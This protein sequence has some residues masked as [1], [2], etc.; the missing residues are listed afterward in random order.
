MALAGGLLFLLSVVAL[1]GPGPFGLGLYHD[2]WFHLYDVALGSTPAIDL[3]GPRPL[4]LIPWKAAGYL[5]GEWLGGYYLFLFSVHWLTAV[6]IFLISR[7]WASRWP[8]LLVAALYLIYP[9]D[10][11]R[12][13]LSS[14]PGRSALLLVLAAIWLGEVA[15]STS[16]NRHRALVLTTAC[17][18]AILGLLVYELPLVLMAAWPLVPACLRR[19]WQKWPLCAWLSVPVAFLTWRFLGRTVMGLPMATPA[20]FILDPLSMLDRVARVAYN[21]FIEGWRLG[22]EE[23]LYQRQVWASLVL[24]VLVLVVWRLVLNSDLVGSHTRPG[25]RRLVFAA[26]VLIGAGIAPV[27]PTDHWLGRNA[28]TF[29]ARILA[30]AIPG[31]AL[32][33]AVTVTRL[34]RVGARTLL[35]ALLLTI[36]IA[37]HW[38]IRAEAVANARVQEAVADALSRHSALEKGSFLVVAGLPPNRLAYDM[39]FGFGFMIGRATG[40]PDLSGVGLSAERDPTSI[41]AVRDGHLLVHQGQWARIPVARVKWFCWQEGELKPIAVSTPD[42]VAGA[43]G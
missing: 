10:A 15:S 5:F 28:G 16:S 26:L 24:V 18:F 17:L 9:A 31:A 34:R 4:H 2:D 30:D 38:E 39:P 12:F 3:A 19:P 41:L 21:L 29:A 25:T 13:W 36:G 1:V 27:V 14:L 40:R 23:W 11:S 42:E 35:I 6:V 32:L 8:A 33:L 20:N 43:C 22:L 37:F 7:R